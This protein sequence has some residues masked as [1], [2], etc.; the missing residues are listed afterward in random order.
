MTKQFSPQALEFFA[1]VDQKR[2]EMKKTTSTVVVENESWTAEDMIT[3]F[4]LGGFFLSLFLLTIVLLSKL[5]SKNEIGR[6][7]AHNNLHNLQDKNNLE[8]TYELGK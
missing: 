3:G 4:V 7:F 8:F 2:A 5:G 1:R 6:G